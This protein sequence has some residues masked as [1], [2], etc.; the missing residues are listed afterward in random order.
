[1]SCDCTT[2][3]IPIPTSHFAYIDSQHDGDGDLDR[4]CRLT[5]PSRIPSALESC[6]CCGCRLVHQ[7]GT[8]SEASR[9]HL[10]SG[11]DR[12]IFRTHG[13]GTESRLFQAPAML[14][15]TVSPSRQFD[16]DC[17]FPLARQSFQ[18]SGFHVGILRGTG[19]RTRRCKIGLTAPW[20]ID[21]SAENMVHTG[22]VQEILRSWDRFSGIHHREL[23]LELGSCLS[24]CVHQTH[25]LCDRKNK[26]GWGRAENRV[27]FSSAMRFFTTMSYMSMS[28]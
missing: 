1:V 25:L 16:W 7:L 22:G 28:V 27:F 11:R 26:S 20:G 15:G 23:A 9:T 2:A 3:A 6:P 21:F 10:L 24:H 12:P 14:T 8:V 5:G 17:S 13:S 4:R 19:A 18:Q